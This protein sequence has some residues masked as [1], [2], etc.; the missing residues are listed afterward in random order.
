MKRKEMKRI[1]VVL[2]AVG[3]M[4][5][6]A[7]AEDM[8]DPPWDVTGPGTTYQVWDFTEDPDA[9]HIVDNPYGD[10]SIEWPGLVDYQNPVEGPYGDVGV[11]H[12]GGPGTEPQPVTIWVPND[13]DENEVK[14]I[15]WQITSTGSPTPTGNQPGVTVPDPSNPG[16]PGIPPSGGVSH[17]T[18]PHGNTNLPNGWYQ[19]AGYIDIIP[20][21]EGEWIT[22]EFVP[23]TY[24]EQI[25]IH[26]ECTPEPA[27]LSLLALGGLLTLVRRRR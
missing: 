20:N 7:A 11:W 5:A 9:P 14:H 18:H 4:A 13:P 1:V 3:L 26:T 19:Y 16:G 22:F 23:C 8:W 6:S 10:P 21:P 12:I 17:P 27:T 24:I 25:V 15:Q 2:A